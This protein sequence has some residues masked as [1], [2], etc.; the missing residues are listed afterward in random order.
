MIICFYL[1]SYEEKREMDS[2]P[3]LSR[4]AFGNKG[5]IRNQIANLFTINCKQI[6]IIHIGFDTILKI[7]LY[8]F[9]FLKNIYVYSNSDF[10]YL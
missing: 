5:R 7:Q 1:S 3:N 9:Q 2:V 6:S 4:S 10:R 8:C